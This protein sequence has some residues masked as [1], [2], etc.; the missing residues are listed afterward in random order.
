MWYDNH[1]DAIYP[2]NDKDLRDSLER[3]RVH[4]LCSNDSQNFP[5]TPESIPMWTHYADSHKGFCIMFSNA[6]LDT[7]GQEMDYSP[8]EI[9]YSDSM[10]EIT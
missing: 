7:P 6:I 3:R 2:T 10:A 9:E 1:I 8:R 4:C 5:S